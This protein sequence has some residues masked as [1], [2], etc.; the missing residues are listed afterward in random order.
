MSA[1]GEYRLQPIPVYPGCKWYYLHR[2]PDGSIHTILFRPIKGP[3]TDAL[4][5]RVPTARRGRAE[6]KDEVTAAP[7][8]PPAVERPPSRRAR[9]SAIRTELKARQG[10]LL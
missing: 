8:E 6:D 10:K 7:P 2:N 4:K 9:Q 5:R 3:W 1:K